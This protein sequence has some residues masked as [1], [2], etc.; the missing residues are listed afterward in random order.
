MLGCEVAF[1]AAKAVRMQELI[2]DATGAACPCKRGMECPILPSPLPVA[3]PR[4][5]V[6]QPCRVPFSDRR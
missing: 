1:D 5:E 2:E 6:S 3:W 4:Q